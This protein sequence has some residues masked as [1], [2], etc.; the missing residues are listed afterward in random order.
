MTLQ[1]FP[2]SGSI[3][4]SRSDKQSFLL[5]ASAPYSPFEMEELDF[6]PYS[7]N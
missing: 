4:H 6:V 7:T 1:R 5:Q 3:F 2:L